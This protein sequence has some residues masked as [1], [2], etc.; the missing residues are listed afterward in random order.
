MHPNSE[1]IKAVCSFVSGDT[2]TPEF[3]RFLYSDPDIEYLLTQ[4]R[5]PPYSHTGHTLFHY[6]IALHYDNPGDVLT[7][8]GALRDFL[9]KLGV[10]ITPSQEPSKAYEL[11]RSAQPRWVD[12]D[13]SYLSSI[14]ALAPQLPPPSRKT[15]L[16][17]RILERFRYL[18]SPPRWIQSPAWPMGRDGPMVFLG[19]IAIKDYLHDNGAV[20]VFHDPATGE[21]TSI[22]QTY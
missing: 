16:K 7:A 10:A 17:Q 4:E 15:W 13:M 21:C 19:Q 18:S 6:L 22:I 14:L 12:A 8:H 1:A 20:Y 11:L 2:P 5:A 9:K 3:E